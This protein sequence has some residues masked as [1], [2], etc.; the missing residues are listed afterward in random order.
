V[1]RHLKTQFEQQG[2]EVDSDDDFDQGEQVFK[3]SKDN[4]VKYLN[5]LSFQD[6]TTGRDMVVYTITEQVALNELKQEYGAV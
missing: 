3:L 2:Y 1:R 4:E 6:Q 5:I